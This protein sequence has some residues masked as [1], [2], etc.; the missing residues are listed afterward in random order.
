M[1]ASPGSEAIDAYNTSAQAWARDAAVVYDR[2]AQA[3]VA[4]WPGPL[5]G[6]RILD[7]GAGSGAASRAVTAVGGVPVALDS[8]VQMLRRC[9]VVG[10]VGDAA[11]CPLRTGA[12]DGVVATFSLTHLEDPA[13]GFR[14]AGRVTVAG[15]PVLACAHTGGAEH[16]AKAV[17]EEVLASEGWSSPGWFT[18]LRARRGEEPAILLDAAVAAG[19]VQV[20]RID[21]DVDTGV[22]DPLTMVLWRLAMAHSAPFVA[23]LAPPRREA[24]LRR[25]VA[26]LGEPPP[27]VVGV[28]VIRGSAPPG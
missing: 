16:P 18:A 28:A 26:A 14:E 22:R 8:A 11:A 13:A 17:V 20:E 15:G 3:V 2:L 27:L 10:V 19:L 4:C 6:R 12:V 21:I 1:R 25:A 5:A 23:A 7:M 24:L 9:G